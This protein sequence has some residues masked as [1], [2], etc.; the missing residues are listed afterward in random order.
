MKYK[1]R[2][3]KFTQEEFDEHYKIFIRDFKS[4]YLPLDIGFKSLMLMQGC[5][6]EEFDDKINEFKIKKYNS[7]ERN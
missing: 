4:K 5:S 2:G 1:F 6:E 7:G 3:E